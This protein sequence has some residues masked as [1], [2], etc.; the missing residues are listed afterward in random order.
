MIQKVNAPVTVVLVS[1]SKTRKA[2]PARVVWAGKKYNILRTTF[3]TPR[4]IGRV[5][6]HEYAVETDSMV[7]VL[8]LNTATQQWLLREID[9]G[10]LN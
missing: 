6:Y 2:D 7:M 5:L 4:F 10:Q 8:L 9:D 1:N 3:H